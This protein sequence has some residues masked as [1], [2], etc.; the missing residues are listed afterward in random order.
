MI[1]LIFSIDWTLESHRAQLRV[2]KQ[3]YG[4]ALEYL[5]ISRPG[6]LSYGGIPVFTST[7]YN[8]EEEEEKLQL[9]AQQS[10]MNNINVELYDNSV[11]L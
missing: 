8:E 5:A 9:I 6:S 11:T 10:L 2:S 1:I 7:A 3:K 4:D